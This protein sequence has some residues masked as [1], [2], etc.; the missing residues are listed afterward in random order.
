MH[1]PENL[2][3]PIRRIGVAHVL[4]KRP[5]LALGIGHD[6][7]PDAPRPIIRRIENRAPG[8]DRAFACRGNVIDKDLSDAHGPGE[9]PTSTSQ[10]NDKAV[11]LHLDMSDPAAR[12]SGPDDFP[13]AEYIGQPTNNGQGVIVEHAWHDDGIPSRGIIDGMV[14]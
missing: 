5:S 10:Q 7:L 3:V 2:T 13:H 4:G 1:G 9:L 6:R 14:P 8:I 11:P 12:Q